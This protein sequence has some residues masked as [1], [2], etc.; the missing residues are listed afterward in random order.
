MLRTIKILDTYGDIP[1]CI[2]KLHQFAV[3]DEMEARVTVTTA[4]RSKGLEWDDVLLCDDFPDFL[5]GDM[6]EDERNDE[7]N[8]LYVACTRAMRRL[9]ISSTMER[10]LNYVAALRRERQAP[11]IEEGAGRAN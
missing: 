6:D 2:D 5:S 8:L 3:K 11:Q 7:I 1:A 10:V 9:Y 4:H